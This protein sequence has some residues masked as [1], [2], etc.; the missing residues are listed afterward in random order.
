MKNI[1][2]IYENK[3]TKNDVL[4]KNICELE[5]HIYY[6]KNEEKD[7]K[8]EN[9]AL[10]LD[11]SINKCKTE[12]N[13]CEKSQIKENTRETNNSYLGSSRNKEILTYI[14]AD[15]FTQEIEN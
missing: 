10:Y 4:L 2:D 9:R 8:I 1:S 5:H 11:S 6:E 15:N 7:E 14:E 13:L 3:E 12:V